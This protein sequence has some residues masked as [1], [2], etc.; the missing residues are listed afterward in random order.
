VRI[1]LLTTRYNFFI[2]YQF[3][4]KKVTQGAV[5]QAKSY[6]RLNSTPFISF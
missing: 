3:K 4:R 5:G 2:S 1:A 6:S